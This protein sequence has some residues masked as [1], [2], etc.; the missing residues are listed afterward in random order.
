MTRRDISDLALA[1]NIPPLGLS[2]YKVFLN[3]GLKSRSCFLMPEQF[4][5]LKIALN[6]KN[7]KSEKTI[8]NCPATA[9][10]EII[11]TVVNA[12]TK[13]CQKLNKQEPA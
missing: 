9:R 11:L 1:M 8:S 3:A 2:L 4:L 13:P 7:L 10:I 5:C 6:Q 12:R